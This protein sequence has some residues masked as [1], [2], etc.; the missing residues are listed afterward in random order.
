MR[1]SIR[2]LAVLAVAVGA[3]TVP[4]SASAGPLTPIFSLTWHTLAA[5]IVIGPAPG[6][7]ST[8]TFTAV[9]QLYQPFNDQV[10]VGTFGPTPFVGVLF[11]HTY[12]VSPDVGHYLLKGTVGN[13]P[14]TADVNIQI[15]RYGHAGI[16]GIYGFIGPQSFAQFVPFTIP[17]L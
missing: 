16:V 8:I 5:P 10:V 6:T 1:R 9:S 17:S 15:D 7:G 13:L 4:A 2:R 14:L 11:A 3:L 12:T